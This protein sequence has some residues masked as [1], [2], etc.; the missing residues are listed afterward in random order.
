MVK[1]MPQLFTEVGQVGLG[2][3]AE[4]LDALKQVALD[5]AF[6]LDVEVYTSEFVA[7]TNAV[8]VGKIFG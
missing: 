1:K 3:C 2:V 4:V 8:T 7:N 5:G 6:V